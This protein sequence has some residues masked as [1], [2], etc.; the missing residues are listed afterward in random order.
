M[1]V[2]LTGGGTGGHI[3]P[4]ISIIRDIKEKVPSNKEVEFFY[5]GP[6]DRFAS[7]LLKNEGVKMKTIWAG[8]IR[9]YWTPKAIL[10][11]FIDIFF[12]I[13]IGFFQ[14][15]FYLFL[16]APDLVFS[17]GGFGGVTTVFSAYLLRTPVL[18]HESDV[19]P[20]LANKISSRMALEIFVSFR[21]TE[22]F[23]LDK[24]ILVGN[25]IRKEILNGDKER[26]K[27]T[28]ELTGEKPVILIMGGSQGAQRINNKVLNAF[29]Q[30][31]LDF[32]IIHQCGEDNIEQVWVE[33]GAVL[34]KNLQQYYHPRGFL[35]EKDLAD[36]YAA[37]DLVISRAGSGSI[38]EIAACNIPSILIPL[39]ESAQNH[40]VKNAYAYAEKGGCL[41]IEEPN[42]TTG[43][44]LERISTLFE[45]EE[46]I[47][48]MKRAIERFSKPKASEIIAQYINSYLFS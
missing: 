1:K 34:S 8:K 36:A 42:F 39:P 28:F 32:E 5:I 30:F 33:S 18:I 25:P 41:V 9:R 23:P 19:S 37:A 43:F 7:R 35:K 3:F 2:V 4:L 20:G 31:L 6:E 48:K 47:R 40:Q 27:E 24:M 17:K 44:F 21:K 13:P 15:F 10:K 26:A 16:L 14:S 11:N 46:K 12:K 38:F 29:P 45:N 22:Y